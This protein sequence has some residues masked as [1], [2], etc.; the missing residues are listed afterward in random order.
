MY[1][2]RK[3][4]DTTKWTSGVSSGARVPHVV[5]KTPQR[6]ATSTMIA[7]MEST[8]LP[9]FQT[10]RLT[11]RERTLSDLE[12]CLEMDRDPDVIRFIAGPWDDP[13][14]HRAFVEQRIFATYP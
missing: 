9:I 10:A 8:A 4:T 14:A 5:V 12:P 7:P 3:D 1:P 6:R 11:L 2:K 13:I